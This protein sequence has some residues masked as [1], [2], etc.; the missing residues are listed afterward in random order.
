MMM[1][2]FDEPLD[3][4]APLERSLTVCPACGAEIDLGWAEVGDFL[5]CVVCGT[6][7]QV[8]SLDPPD[9]DQVD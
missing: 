7:M 9:V 8:L 1:D 4:D 2:D 5:V 3:D 6:E